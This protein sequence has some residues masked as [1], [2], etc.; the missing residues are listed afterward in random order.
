M[1][2]KGSEEHAW[3][4]WCKKATKEDIIK[5]VEEDEQKAYKNFLRLFAISLFGIIIFGIMAISFELAFF[6]ISDKVE[7]M[8][9][10][11]EYVCRNYNGH[12]ETTFDENKVIISCVN[13][14]IKIGR[15]D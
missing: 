4:E 9:D 6:S 2:W 5:V 14:N 15:N 13:K 3:N 7:P 8:E 1:N 12:I 11:E 10:I